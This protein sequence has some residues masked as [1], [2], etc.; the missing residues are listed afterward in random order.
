MPA[1]SVTAFIGPSLLQLKMVIA[2]E[3]AFEIFL[4]KLNEW[5]VAEPGA[6]KHGLENP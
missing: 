3:C 2:P 4:I 6:L 1:A 5:T